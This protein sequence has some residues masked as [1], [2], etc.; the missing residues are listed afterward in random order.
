MANDKNNINELVIDDDD[1]TAELETLSLK[2]LLPE[3]GSDQS[4]V[5]AKTH[6]FQ[7][8]ANTD[9]SAAITELEAELAERSEAND[10]LRFDM[11]QLRSKWQGLETEYKAREE[12]TKQQ[13]SVLEAIQAKL[14]KKSELLKQRNK[15][16][17]AL[18]SEIRD[19]NSEY[20]K[21]QASI[22][23]IAKA[24]SKSP[25]DVPEN[26]GTFLEEQAGQLVSNRILIRELRAQIERTNSYADELRQHLRESTEISNH[27]ADN[28]EYLE[29]EL[30]KAN[31]KIGKLEQSIESETG[32][33][34]ELRVEIEKIQDAH[35]EEIGIIRFELGEAQDTLTE[36]ES[37][38]QQLASDLI[39]TRS[40]RND[41]EKMRIKSEES[42]QSKL[43]QLD[44]ENRHLRRSV[45]DLKSNLELKSEAVNYFLCELAKKTQ[46]IESLGE[47]EDVIDDID[48]RVSEFIDEPVSTE[49]DRVTRL[50]IGSVEGQ[51]LR[52]PLFKD[53]LTIGRTEQNDIQL[54]ASYVSRRHAVIVTDGDRTRVIDWGS[55][56]GVF[57]NSSR[58]TE[59]FLSNGDNVTIGTADFRYEERPKRD[60]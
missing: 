40:Y 28:H 25:T 43:E 59:H 60:S 55:K 30:A 58:V 52:F 34:A 9:N 11:E 18:K 29:A 42:N 48:D 46:Q 21:L 39:D 45:D 4:E 22:D 8:Q 7:K 2:Q 13:N 37:V 26:E 5:A 32:T 54:K 31:H 20:S 6:G 38:S 16:I 57:V 36:Q 53:R 51:E 14:A 24:A 27:A 1:P 12:I 3:T 23:D 44:R 41:L 15:S 33:T 17:K 49:R 19:R 35:A 47:I 56:N 10:R 50:L